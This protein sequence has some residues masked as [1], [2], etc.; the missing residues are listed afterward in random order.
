MTPPATFR[1]GRAAGMPEHDPPRSQELGGR[2]RADV[3]EKAARDEA[4]RVIE[5]WNTTFI[6]RAWRAVVADNPLCRDGRYA[7]DEVY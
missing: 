2:M 6:G 4:V 3:A 5:R 1:G 7:L